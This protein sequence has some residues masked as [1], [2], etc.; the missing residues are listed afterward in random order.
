MGIGDWINDNIFNLLSA[1]GIIGSLC[2]TAVSLRSEA[3]TRRIANL[4][5]ITG[6]HREVWKL[7]FE[8][9][10]LERVFDPNA[11]VAKQ[12]INRKEELFVNMVIAHI[13]AVF[14]AMQNELVIKQEG[15]RRDV[16]QF[17]SLPI[18]GAIWAKYRVLQNDDFAS[19]VDSCLNWK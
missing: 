2:F 4:I 6:S 8:S 5:N 19:F 10:E 7:Y 15:L 3:K 1:A 17:L 13:N 12:G 16:S 11:N 9:P 18:P 14:Y